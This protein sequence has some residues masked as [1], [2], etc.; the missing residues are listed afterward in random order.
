MGKESPLFTEENVD[1]EADFGDRMIAK[2]TFREKHMV[3]KEKCDKQTDSHVNSGYERKYCKKKKKKKTG[4]NGNQ[5]GRP[6]L[7]SSA[8]KESDRSKV[9]KAQSNRPEV[10]RPIPDKGFIAFCIGLML[11]FISY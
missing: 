9:E 4:S 1:L 8:P 5:K 11:S 7:K 6:S 3:M 10:N 2:K